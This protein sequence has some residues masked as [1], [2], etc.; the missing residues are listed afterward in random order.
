MESS[1]QSL[2]DEIFLHLEIEAVARELSILDETM[3]ECPRVAAIF[4]KS[5]LEL[6]NNPAAYMIKQAEV[7][8]LTWEN[9]P[10]IAK[11]MYQEED[12]E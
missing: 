8:R 11:Y 9:Q 4:H 1:E 5:K 12:R 6:L 2:F 7:A 3:H 10:A